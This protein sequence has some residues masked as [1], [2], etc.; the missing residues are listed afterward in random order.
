M[1]RGGMSTQE[2]DKMKLKGL[3]IG[4]MTLTLLCGQVMAV[5]STSGL[6]AMPSNQ[7]NGT[8]R[9]MSMGAAVG[10]IPQGSAFFLGN[11]AGLGYLERMELSAHHN[12][13]LGESIH[14][15]GVFGK[16]MGALGSIAMKLNYST[17]GTFNGRDAFGNQTASYGASAM[18]LGLGWGKQL[19]SNMAVGMS[20]RW[21]SQYLASMSYAALSTDLGLLWT[22]VYP[23]TVGL[24]YANL[25]TQVAGKFL[26]SGLRMGVSYQVTPELVVAAASELKPVGGFDALRFGL[27]DWVFS[28]MAIRVGYVQNFVDYQLSGI[29][30]VTA[31]LGFKIREFLLDYAVVPTGE[32]GTSHRLSFT[33]QGEKQ[34]VRVVKPKPVAQ[35]PMIAGL[36][37]DRGVEGG[38]TSVVIKGRGFSGV[39]AVMFGDVHAFSFVVHSDSKI[40]AKSPAQVGEVDVVVMSAAGFSPIVNAD[41]FTYY[42]VPVPIIPPVVVI[43]RE[44][45]MDD[46]FFD[47]DKSDVNESAQA[48]LKEHIILLK[49]SPE[50]SICISG[51]TSASGTEEYNQALSE[52]RANAVRDYLIK[53][54]INENRLTVI[55]YGKSRPATF[56]PI[57][58]QIRSAAARS[59]MRV[60]FEVGVCKP[61]D[62]K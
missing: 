16:P 32:L 49:D 24:I 3:G 8:A 11:P 6:L 56:E 54:G 35:P 23:L 30:G 22:P 51:Y 28:M 50:L 25:G 40:T 13:G 33:Y 41:R 27:E 12:S 55:G 52:R 14:E 59:N 44:I 38:G 47:Y 46:S 42:E 37:P 36:E 57:P 4:L 5:E 53:G 62:V 9:V 26:D 48:L 10:G 61:G 21:N 31:G 19:F 39:T 17:N 34:E 45:S 15:I 29:T 7:E 2:V 18:G 43:A 60:L 20:V 58:S 1:R